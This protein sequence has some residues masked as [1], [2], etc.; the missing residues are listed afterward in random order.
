[1]H[2]LLESMEYDYDRKFVFEG[3]YFLDH[4]QH[5]DIT[6]AIKRAAIPLRK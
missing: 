2:E 6:E 3:T 4:D 5:E 1:M